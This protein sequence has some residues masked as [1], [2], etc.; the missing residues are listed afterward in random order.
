V[1]AAKSMGQVK[2]ARS[3]KFR[4]FRR[5]GRMDKVNYRNHGPTY[6]SAVGEFLNMVRERR[7]TELNTILAIPGGARKTRKAP[8]RQALRTFRHTPR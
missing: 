5:T 2:V 8:V 6:P 1:C 4:G 3:L 7:A